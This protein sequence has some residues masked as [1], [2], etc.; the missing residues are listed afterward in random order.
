M[1]RGYSLQFAHRSPHFRGIIHTS[2]P[3]NACVGPE[4]IH[5]LQRCHENSP[6]SE[7]RVGLLQP[8]LPCSQERRRVQTNSRFQTS[9]SGSNATAVQNVNFETDPRT[10][11]ARGLVSVCGSE[12]RLLSYPNSAPSQT[13]F[14]IRFRGSGLSVHG[15]SIGLSLAHALLRSA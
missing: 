15:P 3:D 1:E 9:E 13:V 5:C 14:E 10:N 11:S 2:V 6:L 7:Q 12:R 8:I 4:Y